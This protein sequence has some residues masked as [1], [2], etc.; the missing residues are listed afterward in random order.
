M[1]KPDTATRDQTSK[2]HLVSRLLAL[3]A[4]ALWISS[5]TQVGLVIDHG[6]S[7][8]E[9]RFGYMILGTGWLGFGIFCAAWYANIPFLLGVLVLLLKQ[10][11]P[12]WLSA[13]TILLALDTFRLTEIPGGG[14]ADVYAYG[15]GVFL[16]LNALLVLAIAS[17]VRDLE[18][19]TD[20]LTLFDFLKSPLSVSYAIALVLSAGL[21]MHFTVDD[22]AGASTTELKYLPYG[23]IKRGTVCKATVSL[24]TA[25]IELSGPLELV[26]K[27]YPLDQPWLFLSWG[28]PVVRK[29]SIDYALQDR[30][31]INSIYATTSQGLPAARF[32]FEA[33]DGSTATSLEAALTSGDGTKTAFRQKWTRGGRTGREYCP[34]LIAY[35]PDPAVPPFSL[36]LSTLKLPG[37]IKL[38]TVRRP[39]IAFRGESVH[40]APA[41]LIERKGKPPSRP[42]KGNGGCPADIGFLDRDQAAIE[43]GGPWRQSLRVVERRYLLMNNQELSVTCNDNLLYLYYFWPNNDLKTFALYLQKRTLPEFRVDWNAIT[44]VDYGRQ[45]RFGGKARMRIDS[46]AEKDGELHIEIAEMDSS[47]TV[48]LAVQLPPK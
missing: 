4:L 27:G 31:D 6:T 7:S 2:S 24:P 47:E 25:T 18:A 39:E 11:W 3:L 46:V 5:L 9:H 22:H 36:L 41:R 20:G 17:A 23:S 13:I 21:Y 29:N 14:R 33:T 44:H 10:R 45:E 32:S 38:P 8:P 40:L 12:W 42:V 1:G 34:D 43:S 16:W 37:G 48:G 15:I 28:I 30:A 35:P 19:K 26:G